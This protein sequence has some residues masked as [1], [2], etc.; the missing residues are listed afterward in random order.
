MDRFIE[1]QGRDI[2]DIACQNLVKKGRVAPVVIVLLDDGRFALP[3]NFDT[4]ETK[5]ASTKAAYSLLQDDAVRAI[6]VVSE[7]WMAE[8]RSF[9]E[10]LALP[11]PSEDPQR[12]EVV[13]VTVATRSEMRV[14]VT[15]YT[16]GP[17]GITFEPA[18]WQD[19]PQVPAW[20]DDQPSTN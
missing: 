4:V 20:Q 8:R 3:L 7:G 2:M 13:T 9:A 10:V 12:M 5:V 19:N 17:T 6:M 16:R 11:P 1:A 15:K 18:E 14:G